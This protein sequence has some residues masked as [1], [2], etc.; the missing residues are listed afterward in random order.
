MRIVGHLQFRVSESRTPE[1]PGT[2][3]T[4]AQGKPGLA[5][6]WENSEILDEWF[7]VV[8]PQVVTNK[9]EWQIGI[10]E[11]DVLCGPFLRWIVFDVYLGADLAVF[12]LDISHSF[13]FCCCNA[14]NSGGT[15]VAVCLKYN[16]VPRWSMNP[17][18]FSCGTCMSTCQIFVRLGDPRCPVQLIRNLIFCFWN[19]MVGPQLETQAWKHNF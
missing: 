1:L 9:L 7:Y 8:L 3:Q 16:L 11:W 5:K 14:L 4:R 19:S 17:S 2:C 6:I 13:F 18:V 12:S 15:W 10:W